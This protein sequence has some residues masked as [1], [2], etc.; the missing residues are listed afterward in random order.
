MLCQP[1][2]LGSGLGKGRVWQHERL[3]ARPKEP[4]RPP[5]PL[6]RPLLVRCLF[7]KQLR[8]NLNQQ[9]PGLPACSPRTPPLGPVPFPPRA[10]QA[11]QPLRPA[12]TLRPSLLGQLLQRCRCTLLQT[13]KG[14]G[15]EPKREARGGPGAEEQ[16]CRC[17]RVGRPSRGRD[18]AALFGSC[19]AA[20]RPR[21]SIHARPRP[22][23]GAVA[24]RAG[25]VELVCAGSLKHIPYVW[26]GGEATH[27]PSGA[28]TYTRARA[29]KPARTHT[30]TH[31]PAVR[32]WHA[33]PVAA[34]RVG[35]RWLA[36]SPTPPPL[37][38]HAG[39]HAQTN[40][41]VAN[42]PAGPHPPQA[43]RPFRPVAFSCLLEWDAEAP[44]PEANE[45][46]DHIKIDVPLRAA[47]NS[48]TR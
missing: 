19:V 7:E 25:A 40:A 21:A 26:H 18:E 27:R 13:K 8:N 16:V 44:R 45:H 20:R 31:T 33:T 47:Q 9:A 2:S 30:Q 5:A 38:H 46:L 39:M 1:R 17:G 24:R 41:R 29:R 37:T 34:P 4:A 3:L 43:T 10:R 23:H 36:G 42:S 11:Q 22:R 6:P 35:A 15:D 14:Q 12:A 32:A 28:R 48:S